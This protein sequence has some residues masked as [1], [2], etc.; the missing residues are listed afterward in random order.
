MTTSS[1]PSGVPS[2]V[3]HVI[4]DLDGTLLDTEPFYIQTTASIFARHGMTLS[5]EVRALMIGRP[6]R[7]AV[8][9]M[10]EHT[11]LPMTFEEFVSERERLLAELFPLAQPMAGARELTDHLREHGVP[12]A[13]A[14]SSTRETL[15]Q[16]VSSQPEWFARF[17]AVLCSEDV[18]HGKPAPDIF[19]ETARRLD[20][21]PSQCLVFEDAPAGVEGAL[22]AGMQVVAVPEPGFEHLVAG[23]HAV[24][25]SLLAFDPASWGLP[26]RALPGVN[27]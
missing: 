27:A 23:A 18:R 13:I 11:G 25:E 14:T 6:T 2:G 7:I 8:P 16:K 24:V 3:T 22:A 9:M 5:P 10:L 17:D 15:A 26:P 1:L 4:F 21:P 20:A 12:Q 19:L